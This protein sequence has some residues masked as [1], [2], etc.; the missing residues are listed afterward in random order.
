MASQNVIPALLASAV[1]AGC[2][3]MSETDTSNPTSDI[4]FTY[5]VDELDTPTQRHAVYDRVLAAAEKR[6]AEISE[7]ETRRVC[8]D[9]IAAGIV[10]GIGNQSLIDLH[11]V[12]RLTLPPETGSPANFVFHYTADETEGGGATTRL[13]ER[14]ETE[15]E[16]FCTETLTELPVNTCSQVLKARLVALIDSDALDRRLSQDRPEGTVIVSPPVFGDETE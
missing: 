7:I 14:L 6:C 11:A 3:H 4:L 10:D 13:Y 16:A 5:E 2:A 12:S 1:L 9:E 8:I 15:A